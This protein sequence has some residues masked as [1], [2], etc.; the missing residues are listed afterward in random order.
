MMI[1][2]RSETVVK[3]AAVVHVAV[4]ACRVEAAQRDFVALAS[5]RRNCPFRLDL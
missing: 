5:L 4:P 3:L 1:L 2:L